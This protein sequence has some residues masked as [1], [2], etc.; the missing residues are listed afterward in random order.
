MWLR[1]YVPTP[2]SQRRWCMLS[3]LLQLIDFLTIPRVCQE[4]RSETPHLRTVISSEF[5]DRRTQC[6]S[7]LLK[8]G[9][10][11]RSHVVQQL[12]KCLADDWIAFHAL[13]QNDQSPKS[14]HGLRD[15]DTG[16]FC[17]VV[18]LLHRRDEPGDRSTQGRLYDHSFW[19][20]VRILGCSRAGHHTE[21]IGFLVIELFLQ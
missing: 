5:R 8:G 9:I 2:G 10:E 21:S 18:R 14:F 20:G 19:A 15:L 17:T 3:G 6:V 11:T 7:Y 16:L 13:R 4:Q 1:F 12:Y